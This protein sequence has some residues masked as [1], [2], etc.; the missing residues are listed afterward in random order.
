MRYAVL[1]RLITN[2]CVV[3]SAGVPREGKTTKGY[4]VVCIDVGSERFPTD[5]R[6]GAASDIVHERRVTGGSV[7]VTADVTAAVKKEGISPNG[8]VL[9]PPDV[10]Q[11]GCCA[12]RS[13]GI[14]VV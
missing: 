2:G 12:D 8:R 4:I 11:Q 3:V 7:G 13:I 1:E 5:G 9:C 14:H 6:V 10:E